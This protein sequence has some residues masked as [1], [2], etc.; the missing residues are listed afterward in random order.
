MNK[1]Q[2]IDVA[3]KAFREL[4]FKLS[5]E[6]IYGMITHQQLTNIEKSDAYNQ[7]GNLIQFDPNLDNEDEIG[8]K[9]YSKAIELNTKNEAALLNIISTFGSSP[10]CHQNTKLLKYAYEQ[11]VEIEYNFTLFDLES[12]EKKL[13]SHF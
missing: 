7:L 9:Y 1:D 2:I 8:L 3:D 6:L 11:L 13:N 5:F 10:N 4:N 12:I